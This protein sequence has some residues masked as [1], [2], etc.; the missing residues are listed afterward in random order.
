MIRLRGPS[1][2]LALC[3][4]SPAL[5]QDVPDP[6]AEALRLGKEGDAYW[7]RGRCDRAIKKWEEAEGHF[8]APTLVFRIARCRAMLG[9]VVAATSGFESIVHEELKPNAPQP[10]VEAHE[11]AEHWLSGVKERVARLQVGVLAAPNGVTVRAELDGHELPL[12]LEQP[13]DPGEHA[14]TVTATDGS[15]HDEWHS[16]VKLDDGE[17]RSL[18]LGVRIEQ[19]PPPPPTLRRLGWGLLGGGALVAAVAGFG[20]GVPAAIQGDQLSKSCRELI[21]SASDTSRINALRTNAVVADVGVSIGV[22]AMAAGGVVLIFFPPPK[23]EGPR[24]RVVPSLSGA[25]VSGSF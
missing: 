12:S 4:A 1:L 17:A 16:T 6:K 19:Q 13:Q 5:A 7:E 15:S 18:Q 14:L 24:V 10:W 3:C 8:H 11:A 22:L 23:A 20:F 25:A 21:C 2:L 9:Q